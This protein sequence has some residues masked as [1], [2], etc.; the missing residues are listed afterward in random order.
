MIS[1]HRQ[2]RTRAHVKGPEALRTV[3]GADTRPAAS[4]RRQL[5][6]DALQARRLLAAGGGPA[7][8]QRLLIRWRRLRHAQRVPR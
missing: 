8:R 7:L 5:A 1:T 4:R 2:L 6:A 3:T